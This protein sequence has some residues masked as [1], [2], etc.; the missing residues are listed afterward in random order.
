MFHHSE[1]LKNIILT[2]VLFLIFVEVQSPKGVETFS[3]R[4]TD[5]QRPKE[6]PNSVFTRISPFSE[7]ILKGTPTS[8]TLQ[9]R[10][11]LSFWSLSLT[12]RVPPT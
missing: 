3:I 12:S 8:P 11:F 2:T 6:P 10:V 4:L 9:S 7:E 1:I 5:L